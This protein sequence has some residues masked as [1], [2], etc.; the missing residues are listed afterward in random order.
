MTKAANDIQLTAFSIGKSMTYG[1]SR[2]FGKNT[3]RIGNDQKN[4]LGWPGLGASGGSWRREA[5]ERQN[6]VY[7]A[8]R[9]VGNSLRYSTSF[10][11][12]RR[13]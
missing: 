5:H 12:I 8:D 6:L 11:L 1:S 2:L 3:S 7:M 10:A 4:W 9:H 13:P